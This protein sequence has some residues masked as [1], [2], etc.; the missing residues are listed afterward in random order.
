MQRVLFVLVVLIGLLQGCSTTTS[1]L[2]VYLDG[3][4]Q[5][6]I[7]SSALFVDQ[8]KLIIASQEGGGLYKLHHSADEVRQMVA[9]VASKF[10]FESVA[11]EDATYVAE[12]L[13]AFPDGGACQG[14]AGS[15]ATFTASV[16]TFGIVPAMST[17]CYIV[18]VALYERIDGEL[19]LIGE[20]FANQG[21]VDVYA[22]A[23]E[24]DSYGLIVTKRDEALGLETSVA[25]LFKQMVGDGAF[26]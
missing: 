18:S 12:L 20:F 21:R 4:E 24:I 7:S 15:G 13:T 17:H 1:D 22:G 23:N 2:R 25:A 10:G 5:S 26:E 14:K 6:Q 9:N 19:L 3:A 16:L 11:R 8:S